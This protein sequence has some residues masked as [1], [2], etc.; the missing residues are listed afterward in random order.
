MRSALLYKA[1]CG[2]HMH[3]EK[4]WHG[5]APA[6]HKCMLGIIGMAAILGCLNINQCYRLA[7]CWV[8]LTKAMLPSD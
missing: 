5:A 7:A 6:V 3:A 4:N 2:A 8:P 1:A